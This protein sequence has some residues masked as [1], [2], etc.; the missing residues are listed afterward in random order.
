MHFFGILGSLMFLL[1]FGLFAYIGGTKLYFMFNNLTAK[2][3][4]DMSGFYIALTSMIIGAQLFLT[5][6]IA[7]MI[8]RNAYD[9]N[10]YQVEKEA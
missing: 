3:I 9:R 6:F 8:S 2:N 4:A 5:G 10:N 1:G 7:E